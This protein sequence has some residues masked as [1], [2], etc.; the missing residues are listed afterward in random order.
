VFPLGQVCEMAEDDVSQYFEFGREMNSTPTEEQEMRA[1]DGRLAP[2]SMR[3]LAGCHTRTTRCLIR[4]DRNR[5]RC[6]SIPQYDLYT[7]AM[8]FVRRPTGNGLVE[9][10]G[11]RAPVAGR[12]TGYAR[13]HSCELL[14][15]GG[16][17]PPTSNPW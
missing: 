5:E 8:G 17:T 12:T 13:R 11:N 6:E 9:G 4:S 1:G 14:A 2:L 10:A 7:R 16:S 15:D 3:P